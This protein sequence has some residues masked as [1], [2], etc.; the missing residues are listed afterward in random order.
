MSVSPLAAALAIGLVAHAAFVS[1]ILGK[2]AYEKLGR[3]RDRDPGAYRRM[4]RIWCGELW[5]MAAIALLIVAA[6]PGLD[7]AAIGLRLPSDT[8]Y[9]AG[10]LVGF[11]F[12][13]VITTV[14]FRK[15]AAR[16]RK[17]PG[18]AAHHELLPRTGAERWHA[19]ALSVTAGITEEIVFRGLLI[20]LGTQVLGLSLPVAAGLALAVFTA[21]HLYQGWHGMLMVTLIGF[22]LTMLYLRTGDILLPILVHA[23]I[24]LRG[25]VFTPLAKRPQPVTTAA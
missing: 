19:A 2:R 6:E 1:P 14:L 17:I 24:D 11:S 15:L 21:G 5:A 10:L 13:T 22:A 8:G 18:Q 16:G 7:L 20:A 25:L 3:T 23:L 12:M 4:V 9:L